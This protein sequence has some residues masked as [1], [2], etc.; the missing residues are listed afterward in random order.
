MASYKK[1]LTSFG[2]A[3]IRDGRVVE[4]TLWAT[5]ILIIVI[6]VAYTVYKNSARY[7]AY[8]VKT[9]I[10]TIEQEEKPFQLLLFV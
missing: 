5:A 4:K 7:L 8:G 2:V 10:S 1:T 3:R 9:E 6:F